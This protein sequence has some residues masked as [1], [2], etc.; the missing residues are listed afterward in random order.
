VYYR[1]D[2]SAN[3]TVYRKE[4]G[5]GNT[6]WV[7]T[8]NAFGVPSFPSSYTITSYINN[9]YS[10]AWVRAPSGGELAAD[11]AS[12]NGTCVGSD[13]TRAFRV[14]AATYGQAFF[15]NVEYT[16][17]G[18][19]D[20]Q[21]ID[22][23]YQAY[24]GRAADSVGH[25]FWQGRIAALG[26]DGVSRS[27]AYSMEY[28][29]NRLAPLCYASLYV[30]D[31]IAFAGKFI[32]QEIA[33]VNGQGWFY[34]AATDRYELGA[35]TTLPAGNAVNMLVS[36]AGATGTTVNRL[37][38]LTGAPSTAV[39][40][41]TS[42]TE[43]AVGICSANCGTTG[44]ATV[45][46]M[47][48]VTC[49]FDGATTAGN[50]VVISSGTAG[51]CHDA[52][53]SFPNN[54]AAYGRVLTTNGGAGA[55][56]MELMT[57]DIAFQNAG[58]GKS[59]P[60]GSNHQVQINANGVFGGVTL[61]SSGTVLTSNGTGAD[62]TFQTLAGGNL[63]TS[64][65]PLANQFAYFTDATHV[66]GNANFIYDAGNLRFKFNAFVVPQSNLGGQVGESALMWNK[67]Y[68]NEV[69][70]GGT[71]CRVGGWCLS[72]AGGN[73]TTS[74]IF[75]M[76][77]ASGTGITWGSPRFTPAQITA[78]QNDYNPGGQAYF[79]RLSTDASRNITGYTGSITFID[80]EV[81][82]FVNVGTQDVVLKHEDANSVAQNRF[83]NSTGADITLGPNQA[84][85]VIRDDGTNRWRVFKRN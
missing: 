72:D 19:T 39:I 50:Y 80:G 1:T 3:A 13:G 16:A 2:G 44:T 10:V 64:G 81:H 46:I 14:A 31:A 34:N 67:S 61:G 56:V 85:D 77:S 62:P 12:L 52:G 35:P 79:V 55:Y 43:N 27:F 18:R 33:P 4:T 69:F 76:V 21:F 37:A 7:A 28:I 24:L 41:S 63:S 17:R 53:S 22:D 11:T 78:N 40:T 58:G 65:T 36:N 82:L 8:S 66:A 83:L 84:A 60:G 30:A 70:A 32:N 42:D 15:T 71:V 75:K 5:T 23:L 57:P 48:Q 68:A 38:K 45:A 54:Q 51:M 26:R 25:A 74:S 9:F 59:K 20:S 49:D 6:G 29:N 47:G 73:G